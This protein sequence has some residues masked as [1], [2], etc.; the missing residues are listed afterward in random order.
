M[1]YIKLGRTDL[2]VSRTGFGALPIQRVSDLEEATKI[3]RQAYEGGINFFDTA[4]AYTDSETKIGYA[5]QEVRKDV[6]IASKSRA[7]T[8]VELSADIQS[9]LENLQTDYIDIY[10]LHNLPFVPKPDAEDGVYDALLKAKKEGKINHIG[11]T[12]HSQERALEAIFSGLYETLQFPFSVLSSD[13]DLKIVKMCEQTDTGFIAMKALSGGLLTD[14]ELAYNFLNQFDSVVP[15]W[16]IQ[17]IEELEQFLD[18]STNPPEKGEDFEKRLAS[19]REQLAGNFCRGCGY[20]LPCPAQIPIENANRMSL[21]IRRS[22]TAGWFSKE[23][24]E[25]MS[26]IENCTLCRAC[27]KRCPYGLKPY[28]TLPEHLKDYRDLLSQKN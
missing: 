25:K 3:L 20:C 23:W 19:E 8:G 7:T 5:L 9:S 18:F 13:E 16:G 26:C 10:Q 11:F 28:E 21:L 14:I 12:N 27:E 22:P 24:Q 4:R 6:V 2:L 1:E 17:K 15:I